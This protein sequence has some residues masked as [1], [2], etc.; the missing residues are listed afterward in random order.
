[1][2]P[3]PVV[4]SVPSRPAQDIASWRT[5]GEAAVL[6]A[7]RS[8]GRELWSREGQADRQGERR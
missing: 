8:A 1:L 2:P 3:S 4:S 5:T 7:W 6:I